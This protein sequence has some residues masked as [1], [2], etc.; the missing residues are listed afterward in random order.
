MQPPD[1]DRFSTLILG[2][3]E[4]YGRTLSEAAIGLYWQA[5][6]AY[7]IEAVERAFATYVTH[8][9]IGQY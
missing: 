4:L 7:S 5:L 9:D 2:V 8:P 6:S 1:V 3:S